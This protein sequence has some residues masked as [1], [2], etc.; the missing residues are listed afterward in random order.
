MPIKVDFWLVG[1]KLLNNI[2]TGNN[3]NADDSIGQWWMDGKSNDSIV[4]NF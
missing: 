4:K 2:E 3:W 1:L